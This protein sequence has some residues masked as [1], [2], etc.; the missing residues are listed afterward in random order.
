MGYMN[1]IVRMGAEAFIA[2]SAEVGVDG[3]IVPDLPLEEAGALS[4][5]AAARP[6]LPPARRALPDACPVA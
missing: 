3:F 6:G 4:D 5:A 1:P 2:R